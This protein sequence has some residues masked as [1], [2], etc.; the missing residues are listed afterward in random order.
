MKAVSAKISRTLRVPHM[1]ENVTLCIAGH[2]LG[3]NTVIDVLRREGYDVQHTPAGQPI[4]SFARS[5]WN[6][7]AGKHSMAPLGGRGQKSHLSSLYIPYSS[8]HGVDLLSPPNVDHNL[9][10][11]DELLP[12]M[13]HPDN[14]DLLD[15]VERKYKKKRRKQPKKQRLRHFNDLWVRIEER[16]LC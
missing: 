5:Y 7:S 12:H 3:N 4:N 9:Q 13:L 14:L 16:Y 10:Q 6:R 1:A 8:T 11:G 15:K 2:F